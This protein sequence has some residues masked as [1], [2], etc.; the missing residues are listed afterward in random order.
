MGSVAIVS[1]ALPLALAAQSFQNPAAAGDGFLFGRPVVTTSLYG[2]F[3]RPSAQSEVFAFASDNL[4]LDRGD[5][6]GFTFGGN[7]GFRVASRFELQV[8]AGIMVRNVKSESRDFIGTDDLPIEQTT[9]FRRLPVTAGLKYYVTP[10]G[11]SLGKLAWVPARFATYVAA[12]GGT[13]YYSFKQDGEFVDFETL[14]VFG[15]SLESRGWAPAGYGALGV[16]FSLAPRVGL[17]TEARYDFA[18]AEMSKQF[19]GFDRID[20]SGFSLNVGVNFRF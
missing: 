7:M 18:R 15:A 17:V 20:L 9:I 13:M 12:G 11:R 10:P 3:A 2:G 1:M 4:T 14:D 16:D 8:G 6:S 5:F 19:Q